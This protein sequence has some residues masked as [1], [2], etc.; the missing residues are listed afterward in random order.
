MITPG[1]LTNRGK[2]VTSSTVVQPATTQ[3]PVVTVTPKPPVDTSPIFKF[4]TSVS[5][6]ADGSNKL[7][8]F[9]TGIN[10]RN[11]ESRLKELRDRHGYTGL[12]DIYVNT[13][14]IPEIS[15]QSVIT[16]PNQKFYLWLEFDNLDNLPVSVSTESYFVM[17]DDLRDKGWYSTVSG[18]LASYKHREQFFPQVYT[19]VIPGQTE[20][21]DNRDYA[22]AYTAPY[23]RVS[24]IPFRSTFTIFNYD[25]VNHSYAVSSIPTH[26]RE[27]NYK[28]ITTKKILIG[29]FDG[30][31]TNV[32]PT[33]VLIKTKVGD[34]T[35][36][37]VIYIPGNRADSTHPFVDVPNL[38]YAYSETELQR[39]YGLRHAEFFNIRNRVTDRLILSD[40]KNVDIYCN[41]PASPGF[42]DYLI[43][44]REP[45]G[46]WTLSRVT[47]TG[48]QVHNQRQGEVNGNYS[49]I[50]DKSSESNEIWHVRMM[51]PGNQYLCTISAGSNGITNTEELIMPWFMLGVL[52]IGNKYPRLYWKRK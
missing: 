8:T 32:L 10:Y 29:R 19:A 1:V 28:I 11:I 31:F 33:Q 50:N 44:I 7:T 30:N 47:D 40:V 48:K 38:R 42:T 34:L 17:E 21:M 45:V 37:H 4:R 3:P 52:P 35:E 9:H 13:L 26:L 18:G 27:K 15:R 2:P 46:Q 25:S 12:W 36:Y 24:D 39:L 51:K 5:L 41:V 43:A 49:F 20:R 22:I 14:P 16:N 23:F 6:N